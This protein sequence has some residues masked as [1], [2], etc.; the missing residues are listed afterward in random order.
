MKQ[1][2]EVG[3]SRASENQTLLSLYLVVDV[4]TV[5]RKVGTS[6]LGIELNPQSDLE[7][8]PVR[9]I[10][11]LPTFSVQPKICCSGVYQGD[12]SCSARKP[13][14]EASLYQRLAQS[15]KTPSEDLGSMGR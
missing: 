15:P 2:L 1:S 5:S 6:F 10:S 8:W 12:A 4:S 9:F 14:A 13:W 11:W 7:G 3:S